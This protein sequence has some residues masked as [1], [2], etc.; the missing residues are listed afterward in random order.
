[1][2]RKITNIIRFCMDELLP[3]IIR[4]NKYFMYPFYVFAYRGRNIKQ[5]MNFKKTVYQFTSNEYDHFYN[6]LN[7]ISRNRTTDLNE[8]CIDYILHVIGSSPSLSSLIDVGCGNGFLLNLIHEKF[9]HVKLYGFDIKNKNTVDAKNFEYFQG[10]ID[11]LPFQAQQFD[12]VICSHVLEHL[13]NIHQCVSELK[14]I[15]KQKLL[16]VTPCQRYFFYTLDEH[17]HFFEYK[18]K[19]TQLFKLKNFECK[20]ID[21]DWVYLA[22]LT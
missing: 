21:G 7:S 13:I 16:V 20:K 22:D 12:I 8:S 19:L 11:N 6:N 14:K 3:P 17:I 18:E 10:N 2:N 15:T 9:P 5:V 4:D 1:M